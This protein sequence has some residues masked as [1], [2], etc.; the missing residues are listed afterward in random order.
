MSNSVD[1]VLYRSTFHPDSGKPGPWW[2]FRLQVL[3]PVGVTK[4]AIFQ[5]IE[6]EFEELEF[7]IS[8][9][10]RAICQV[11][12]AHFPQSIRRMLNGS[13]FD[14]YTNQYFSTLMTALECLPFHGME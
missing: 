8:Q 1:F 9:D 2:V 4:P 6:R 3:V 12:S 10:D 14:E 7:A 11:L 5:Y 13:L